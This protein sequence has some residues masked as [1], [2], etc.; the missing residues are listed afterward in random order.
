MDTK[1]LYTIGLMSGTSLDGLDIAYCHFSF[2]GKWNFQLLASHTYPYPAEWKE[3]LS[4]LEQKTA[5][6]YAKTNVE[7]GHYFGKK[8]NEFKQHYGISQL[9]FISSHGH[10]IF[11]RPDIGITTQIGDLDSIAAETGNLVVGNFRTFDVALGG[12][13]APLVP[14]GDKLLFSN[15]D[16]CLNLGGFSNISFHKYD[17]RIAF[18]ISPCNI[19]LN[20][21]SNKIGMDYDRNGQTA[22]SGKLID[23]LLEKLNSIEYYSRKAPKSLGKEWFIEELLPLIPTHLPTEDLLRTATE[24]IGFQIAKVINDEK[25]NSVMITGGGALNTFLIECIS[26]HCPN[27]K[28]VIPSVETIN[29]K[30]AIIFAF[31]GVLRISGIN[32]CLSSVTGA[33][34]DN[35]GGNISGIFC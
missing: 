24:H 4:H 17:K 28:V 15:Y 30:E 3:R 1:N 11:H 21:L 6:E 27:T 31:L 8:V 32:N 25:L 5:W 13:G 22:K 7:L 12:Q 23:E 29:Y 14:I 33:N 26:R 2:D 10:T 19:I 18:D 35:C 9:D 20:Y 16:A 34:T